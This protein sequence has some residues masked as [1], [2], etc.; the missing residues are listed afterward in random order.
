MC[1]RATF[2]MVESRVYISVASISAPV[3]GMRFLMSWGDATGGSPK[4]LRRRLD[5]AP[6]GR[7]SGVEVNHVAEPLGLG[8]REAALVAVELAARLDHV[9]G[10]AGA[11]ARGGQGVVGA[12]LAAAHRAGQGV[13][14]GLVGL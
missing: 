2:A 8:L 10:G 3:I 1:G 13:E 7:R 6:V 14:L 11:Q 4:S 9:A 12:L 5:V